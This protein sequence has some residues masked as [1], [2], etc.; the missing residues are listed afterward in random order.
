MSKL[1]IKESDGNE[2]VFEAETREE[3]DRLVDT[4]VEENYLSTV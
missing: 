2:S 3:L 1:V 4:Y